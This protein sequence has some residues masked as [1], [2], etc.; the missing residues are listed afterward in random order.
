[1]LPSLAGLSIGFKY[2]F[3]TNEKLEELGVKGSE[4]RL[5]CS[6][7]MDEYEAGVT[8][9]EVLMCDHTLC[10]DC[11]LQLPE[12]KRC[13]LCRAPIDVETYMTTGSHLRDAEQVMRAMKREFVNALNE[14]EHRTPLQDAASE[15]HLEHVRLLLER[16][17]V[18]DASM[19]DGSTALMF[20]AKNGHDLC[21][22][23]LLE[24][25]AA[26]NAA[27]DDGTTALM[28]ACDGSHERCARAL[29]EH[30]ADVHL[31]DKDGWTALDYA[32][33]SGSEGC[34]RLLMTKRARIQLNSK[35]A[36]I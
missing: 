23:V 6:V 33:R 24:N 35:V 13:P 31:T 25:D 16:G 1:M 17:A 36:L 19:N 18:V 27:N 34:I 7:C 2:K 22:R 28:A 21:A 15:G 11:F 10:R 4:G 12:P 20:A 32:Q 26:V 5:E 9:L 14:S 8:D 30:G 29:L 3:Q